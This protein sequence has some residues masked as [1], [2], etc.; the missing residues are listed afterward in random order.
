MI[1]RAGLACS[2]GATHHGIFDVAFLSHIPRISLYA[3][4]TYDALA[5]AARASS[6]AKHP[7]AIRYPN[8]EEHVF[9]ENDFVDLSDSTYPF[10][11]IDF[12]PDV[13]PEVLFITY[14][15]IISSVREA[16]R[17]LATDGVSA[18]I[19]LVEC[20]KPYEPVCERISSLAKDARQIVYVEEG[21]KNGGAAM[22]TES[23]LRGNGFDFGKTNYDIIAIDDNF[24]SPDKPCDLYDFVG[25]SSRKIH[26]RCKYL[27]ERS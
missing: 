5:R 9:L 27:L 21:I 26:E 11:R 15:Q 18:G 24:A 4:A 12:S 13:V 23:T 6:D 16:K 1:D 25:L 17:L 14:G 7:V 2:D 8:S 22:I 3:P 19:V 10:M 20:L